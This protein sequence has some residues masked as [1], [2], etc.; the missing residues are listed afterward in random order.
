MG[1][2]SKADKGIFMEQVAKLSTK[3]CAAWNAN[4]NPELATILFAS[5]YTLHH[6]R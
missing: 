4:T 2:E 5:L 3:A 1:Q 6:K